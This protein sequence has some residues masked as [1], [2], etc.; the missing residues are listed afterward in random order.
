MEKLMGLILQ[1][2]LFWYDKKYYLKNY[3]QINGIPFEIKSI[4]G[5]NLGQNAENGDSEEAAQGIVDE[6]EGAECLICLSE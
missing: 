2:N 5:L 6:G 4:Y 1:N 3:L